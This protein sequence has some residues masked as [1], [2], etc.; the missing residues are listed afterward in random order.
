MAG[1]DATMRMITMF[2]SNGAKLQAGKLGGANHTLLKAAI[3]E[4]DGQLEERPYIL[5][6]GN[7][8]RQPRHVGFFADPSK[9]YGYFYSKMVAKSIVPGPAVKGLL[10]FVNTEFGSEFNGVLVNYYP[11]GDHY[12]SDHSDSEA[13]LDPN[14]GVVIISAGETRTMHFKPVDESK[15]PP[16]GS[17]RKFKNGAYKL[18]LEH[19]S[20]VAMQ[21]PNFQKAYTHGIP[22]QAKVTKARWSFTFRKH[23]GENERPMIAAASRTKALIEKKLAE[24]SAEIAESEPAAKRAKCE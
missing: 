21:G 11:D 24:A 10:D 22:K 18:D 1:S 17:I 23:S 15:N 16:D 4:I 5:M 13:G 3:D 20:V 12:I 9:T 7:P 6:F 2:E 14:S 19:G 8:V